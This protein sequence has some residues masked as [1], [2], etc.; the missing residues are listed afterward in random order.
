MA[1]RV[2]VDAMGG[3]LAP[4]AVVAGAV[5]A[6]AHAGVAVLLVGPASIVRAELQKHP[7]VPV[8]SL[9]LVDAPDVI[10]MDEPPL[11]ALRRKP[12]ASVKVAAELV[13]RREADASFTAG[14]TGAGLLAAH[15]ALGV[16]PSVARPALAVTVPTRTGSAVLLDAGAN[17]ECRAEH[18]VQFGVMGA[19]YARV[20][21]GVSEPR[22]GLLSI[23]EEAG[24]GPDL[25][26]EA[27][28]RLKATP[29]RFIGNLDARELFSGRADVVV[30][31]GFTGNVALK[32]GEG[33]A[34]LVEAM[35]TDELNDEAIVRAG[36]ADGLRRFKRRVDYAE[37]GGAPLLGLAGLALV[38]HGRSSPQ[39]V[40]NAILLAKRLVEGRIVERL[41][42]SLAHDA[43]H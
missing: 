13:A 12:R 43:A 34:E 20:A 7:A 25:I 27:H 5:R 18:L 38:G 14:H 36:L 2:A 37:H 41:A 11:A 29:L 17:L 22:V 40:E 32:V 31:D 3:D 6:A 39:A 10:G 30:C 21:L 33:L 24:K 19:A 16:L 4:G 23:G 9:D 28:D 15:G 26:R 1:I 35:L 42:E 8:Q